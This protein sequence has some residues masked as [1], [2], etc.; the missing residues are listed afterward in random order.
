MLAQQD[1]VV[2]HMS[3]MLCLI[4]HVSVSSSFQVFLT[5]CK[6]FP[7]LKKGEEQLGDSTNLTLD[8]FLTSENII[9]PPSAKCYST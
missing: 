6:K 4:S 5:S 8:Y 3:A 9:N 1:V 7:F 2:K